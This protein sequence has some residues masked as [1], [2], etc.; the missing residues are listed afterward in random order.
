[1]IVNA[2]GDFVYRHNASFSGIESQDKI[3]HTPA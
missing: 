1:M 3:I 2:E